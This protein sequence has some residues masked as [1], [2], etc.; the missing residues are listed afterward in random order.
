[1]G[2]VIGCID[3][4][5]VEAKAQTGEVDG[6]QCAWSGL[7]ALEVKRVLKRV[8]VKA[9]AIELDERES[10]F[11]EKNRSYVFHGDKAVNGL[12]R[13]VRSRIR[14]INVASGICGGA[15]LQR[16]SGE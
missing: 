6:A 10:G 12:R 4:P 15:V 7:N 14:P 5:D 1:M 13:R 3:V 2:G 11:G 16:R 8:E 9:S